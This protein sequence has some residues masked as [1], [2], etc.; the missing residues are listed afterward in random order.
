M[1]KFLLLLSLGN[2]V[3]AANLGQDCTSINESWAKNIAYVLSGYDIYFGNPLAT[4]SVIDPG[5]RQLIFQAEYSGETTQDGLNCIPD[6]LDIRSCSKSCSYTFT[7]RYVAGTKSYHNSLGVYLGIQGSLG[8]ASFGASIDYKHIEESTEKETS[9]FTQADASCCAYTG[10]IFEYTMPTFHRNFVG[11][12]KSLTELYDEGVYRRFLN[13]FGTH[14]V[15][16]TIMGAVYGQQSEITYENWSK[17]VSDGLDIGLYAGIAAM[18]SANFSINSNTTEAETFNK[19]TKD[20]RMYSKGATPPSDGKPESWMQSIIESPAPVSMEVA[21]IFDLYL[22]EH[23]SPTVQK[24][25]KEATLAYCAKLVEEGKLRSCDPPKE[26]KPFPKPRVWSEW[27]NDNLAY[28]AGMGIEFPVQECDEGQF[29]ESMRWK[30][31]NGYGLVDFQM[32]CSGSDGWMDPA[33]GNL[34]AEY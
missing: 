24:N 1:I 9:L 19:Y 14:Y 2:F 7:S 29:I 33:V 22:A 28:S 15:K 31:W 18:A 32:K 4:S 6:G 8:N 13:T 3:L 10:E 12:L 20:Q 26:D 16:K 11:G 30:E 34:N 21:P 17:M 5:F 23:I 27:S 25:L